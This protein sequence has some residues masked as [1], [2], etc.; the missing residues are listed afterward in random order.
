MDGRVAAVAEG[1]NGAEWRNV[2]DTIAKAT[3]WSSQSIPAAG[4]PMPFA[5]TAAL[6]N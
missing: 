1:W 4:D 5:G 3:A 6:A 2:A